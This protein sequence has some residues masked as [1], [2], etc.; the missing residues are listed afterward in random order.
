MEEYVLGGHR[1]SGTMVTGT[2]NLTIILPE[3]PDRLYVMSG[4]PAA[5][6]HP[7]LMGTY[8]RMGNSSS[9]ESM[10]GG[11]NFLFY[12][13]DLGRWVM[14]S[15]LSGKTG[16]IRSNRTG[17]GRI[18]TEGWSY[19][20]TKGDWVVDSML[21]VSGKVYQV[22]LVRTTFLMFREAISV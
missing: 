16:Q 3:Y 13:D 22:K 14:G 4:G 7:T 19:R 17:P 11:E 8:A 10:E 12:S 9:Y 15:N 2:V 20:N 18:P 1:G 6:C 5:G 21:Q